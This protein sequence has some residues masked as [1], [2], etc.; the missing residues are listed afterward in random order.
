MVYKLKN[1]FHDFYI[2]K[3]TKK[4]IKVGYVHNYDFS[5]KHGHCKLV[6][7]IC[8]TY[9]NTGIGAFASVYFLAKLF[10]TYPLRKV[11]STIYDYNTESLKSNLEAGF[12]EEGVLKNYRYHDGKIHSIHYLSLNRQEFENKMIRLVK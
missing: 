1:E 8:P 6:T 5:L 12:V 3:E 4:N 2:V 11:Y 9:R 7:Y 10:K